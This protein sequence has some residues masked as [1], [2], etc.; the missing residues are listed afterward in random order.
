MSKILVACLVVG[1][2]IFA[3]T[4]SVLAKGSDQVGTIKVLAGP[5]S[6]EFAFS[7]TGY[8]SYYPLTHD[9][10]TVG[11]GMNMI[12]GTPRLD[13]VCLPSGW[14]VSGGNVTGGI[15]LA[16]SKDGSKAIDF[17]YVLGKTDIKFR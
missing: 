3:T 11:V 1:S 17:K 14:T 2:V 12:T 5:C 8:T 9:L 13:N 7:D 15:Q 4:G 16:F 6:Q 10:G